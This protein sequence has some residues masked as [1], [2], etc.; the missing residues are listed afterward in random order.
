[1]SLYAA[2][3]L[4][5]D[6]E[7]ELP[8]LPLTSGVADVSIRRGRI[9]RTECRITPDEEYVRNDESGS[10]RIVRGREILV[11]DYSVVAAE[12][13]RVLLLGRVMAFLL[14]QRGW[15]PLHASGVNIEGSAVL[16]L[17]AAGTGKSTTAAAFHSQGH[18]L[19]TDDVAPVRTVDGTCVVQPGPSRLRL[20]DNSRP[21]LEG[22]NFKGSMQWDKYSYEVGE[23]RSDSASRPVLKNIYWLESTPGPCRIEPLP[24]AA[25]AAILFR[26]SFLKHR[27]SPPDVLSEQLKKCA[28][29]ADLVRVCRLFRPQS[30]GSLPELIGAVLAHLSA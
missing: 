19:I 10:F 17:G 6:S 23:S 8:E 2:F 30:L 3:G 12:A 28:A 21:L 9:S 11:D 26:H 18:A 4:T 13:M 15:L 29:V 7:I 5:F 16:F 25:A 24:A 20:L 1:M 22:R 27:R 14:R